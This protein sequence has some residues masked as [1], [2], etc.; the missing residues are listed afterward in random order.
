MTGQEISEHGTSI[1]MYEDGR[2]NVVMTSISGT[3]NSYE[4]DLKYTKDFI[5]RRIIFEKYR[6]SNAQSNFF[7]EQMEGINHQPLL[8]VSEQVSDLVSRLE[9]DE[10]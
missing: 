8:E 10:I 7:V 4:R 6:V 5:A 9:G 3:R 1:L 2:G